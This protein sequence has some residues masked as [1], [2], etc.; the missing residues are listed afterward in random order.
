MKLDINK[1]LFD[2]QTLRQESKRQRYW[3]YISLALI[4]LI[5]RFI[6]LYFSKLRNNIIDGSDGANYINIAKYIQIYWKLPLTPS[7]GARQFPGLSI[8]ILIINQIFHNIILSSVIVS[9]GGSLLSILLFHL[10]F[11]DFRMSIIYSIFLPVFVVSSAVI[12]SH[13]LA[14]FF[15]LIAVYAIKLPNQSFYRFILLLLSGYGII[16]RYTAAFFIYPLI[17]FVY[18]KSKN[19]S[20]KNILYDIVAVSTLFAAYLFWNYST[21]RVLFPQAIIQ[22]RDFILNAYANF[23]HS[24]YSY[25][26]HSLILGFFD[27]H[28]SFLKKISILAHIFL[29][30]IVIN[31]YIRKVKNKKDENIYD[32]P[33]FLILLITLGFNLCVGSQYGFSSFE[34]YLL[35]INPIIVYG[36]FD[37]KPL[38]WHWIF[39]LLV[40]G[41][42][43]GIIFL[44]K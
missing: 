39:L 20:M 41:I 36:L 38:K 29:V 34:R 33:F 3:Q 24:L 8:L 25:P 30:I 9:W 26:G 32:F 43:Y 31:N 11:R 15:I 35:I 28:F 17:F 5:T 13:G 10:I 40:L 42:V 12:S 44:N 21:I 19:R 23:P 27:P 1:I 4:F 18:I 37:K 14:L 22:E 6:V 2:K 16:V 7:D